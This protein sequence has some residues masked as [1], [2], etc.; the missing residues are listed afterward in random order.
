MD[1]FELQIQQKIENL[2]DNKHQK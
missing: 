2:I 1:F